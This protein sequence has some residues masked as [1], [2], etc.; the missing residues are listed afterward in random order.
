MLV[1]Q[2]FEVSEDSHNSDKHHVIQMRNLQRTLKVKCN[3]FDDYNKWMESLNVLKDRAHDFLSDKLH[4]FNS[5]APIR[6]KQLGHW[7]F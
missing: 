1:D 2:G 4:R 6:Q 7:Y 3:N 5:F